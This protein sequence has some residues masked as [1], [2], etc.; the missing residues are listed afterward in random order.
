M[1]LSDIFQAIAH[2]RLAS[3]DLPQR[4]SNQHEINSVTGLR[5]FFGTDSRIEESINWLFFADDQEI[6]GDLGEITFYD[7]R[8]SHPVRTEW[9]MYYTGDFLAYAEPGDIL[10]LLGTH[11]SDTI[12]GLIFQQDSAWLRAALVLFDI[13]SDNLREGFQAVSQ[14]ELDESELGL[15]EIRILEELGIEVLIPASPSDQDLIIEHFDS[16]LPSTRILSEF[17]REHSD[18]DLNDPDG[19]LIRWIER[20]TEFFNILMDR[21][22][23]HKLESGFKSSDE[24]LNFASSIMNSRKSRMGRVL[25]NHLE[26]LFIAMGIDH[27]REKKTEGKSKPDFLFPGIQQYLDSEFSADLLTMLGAKSSCKD[28]WRQ[29][30][31]EAE[32]ID[33]KHLCTLETGISQDQ[34][35]EMNEYD[36]I[37]VIPESFHTTYTQAQLEY[38]MNIQEFLALV[39]EKQ[40]SYP[41]K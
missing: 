14:R 36:L 4:S 23:M 21:I 31:T 41:Q 22:I 29:V 9:R 16:I 24:F 35:N 30:L 2:K 19:T 39:L 37:L 33:R 27:D 34:T 20:E 7:A 17:A 11:T 10:I 26:A 25:E 8:E 28:R 5:E 32:R 12:H 13:N 6:P 40:G 1:R 15:V 38:I 3:V 18:V